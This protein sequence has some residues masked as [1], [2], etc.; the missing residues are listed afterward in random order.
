[1]RRS[2]PSAA[3]CADI[4][5]ALST[6]CIAFGRKGLSGTHLGSTSFAGVNSHSPTNLKTNFV[7]ALR[8]CCSKI[9]D[10]YYHLSFCINLTTHYRSHGTA[11]GAA[12]RHVP[13]M[14][15][16]K[17]NKTIKYVTVSP[18]S[19]RRTKFP[20]HSMRETQPHVCTSSHRR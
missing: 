13:K 17:S 12:N 5:R 11:A 7:F 2:P 1:M 20:P 19:R 6:M 3:R 15:S 10:S 9:V 18:F 16:Q 4:V 14:R 8:K